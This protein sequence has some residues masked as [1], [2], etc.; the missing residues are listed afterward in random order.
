MRRTLIILT[1]LAA[2]TAVLLPVTGNAQP[3]RPV[4]P[5]APAAAPRPAAQPASAQQQPEPGELT[6]EQQA[7]RTLYFNSCASCHGAD[8]NGVPGRGPDLRDVGGAAAVQFMVGTGR[9]PIASPDDVPRRSPPRFNQVQ[10]DALAAYVGS[11]VGDT[12]VPTARTD[13]ALLTRGRQ[14]YQDN[15][16]ACHGVNGAGSA[17]GGGFDAPSLH[18]VDPD[19]I[20]Q[21]MAIGPG[22]MPVFGGPEWPQ[23]DVDA[24]ATYVLSFQDGMGYGGLPIGGRGPVSEGFVA[25]IIGLGLLVLATRLL[26]TR[27]PKRPRGLTTATDDPRHTGNHPDPAPAAGHGQA[28]PAQTQGEHA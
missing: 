18:P 16:A 13:E 4:T 14:L 27:T 6:P 20:A 3:S 10:I 7:G 25:W 8:F 11:Q 15:C 5:A 21:A 9:M 1:G 28:G 12:D 17:I 19:D 23:E 22:R 26:G 2:L 24:V